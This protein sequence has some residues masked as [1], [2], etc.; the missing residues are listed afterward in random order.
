MS[1]FG[2]SSSESCCLVWIYALSI[3]CFDASLQKFSALWMRSYL[4]STIP[5]GPVHFLSWY[6]QT[7]CLNLHKDVV[8]YKSSN[9]LFIIWT[10]FKFVVSAMIMYWK[11]FCT[12]ALG[13]C[14]YNAMARGR[15]ILTLGLNN[16]HIIQFWT[17]SRTT[18]LIHSKYSLC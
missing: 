6:L 10:Y 13:L 8:R 4:A 15:R 1:S 16:I 11:P 18:S 3:Y 17:N 2:T 14:Q 9:H 5:T 12:I 7:P